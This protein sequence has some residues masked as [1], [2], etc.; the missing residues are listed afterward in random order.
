MWNEQR[1]EYY[2]EY[3][4]AAVRMNVE[5]MTLSKDEA[6]MKDCIWCDSIYVRC[7]E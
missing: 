1:M 2:P 6:T 3:C 5:N 4:C 7:S